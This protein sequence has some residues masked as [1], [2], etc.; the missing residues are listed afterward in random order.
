MICANSWFAKATGTVLRSCA[1]CVFSIGG[2]VS[3][4]QRA[5]L[6]AVSG[7]RR[8]AIGR[9]AVRRTQ[10]LFGECSKKNVVAGGAQKVKALTRKPTSCAPTPLCGPPSATP[11]RLA[12]PRAL[13]PVG[14]RRIWRAS[15]RGCTSD[16]NNTYFQAG[17]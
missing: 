16:S 2:S 17:D 5:H 8:R 13:T 9:G 15:I 1:A 4:E 11:G 3:S 6:R 7:C 12:H 14:P 10:G